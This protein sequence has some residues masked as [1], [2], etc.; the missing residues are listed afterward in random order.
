LPEGKRYRALR[1]LRQI[2]AAGVRWKWIE[3]NAAVLAKNPEPTPGEIDPFD[4]WEEI[5]AIGEE[6]DDVGA[7]TTKPCRSRVCSGDGS[8]GARTRD[9]RRDRPAL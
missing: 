6:L 1:S 9:L 8:D 2:L 5:E 4:S 3:D 7:G